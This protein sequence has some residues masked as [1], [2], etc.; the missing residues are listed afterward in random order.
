MRHLPENE[1]GK[2]QKGRQ[3]YIVPDGS[4]AHYRRKRSRQCAYQSCVRCKALKRRVEEEIGEKGA[5]TEQCGKD[6]D[7]RHQFDNAT[8]N[9]A[10]PKH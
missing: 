5:R 6:V 8:D 10:D 4:P 3:T 9:K 7:K 1:N 2:E